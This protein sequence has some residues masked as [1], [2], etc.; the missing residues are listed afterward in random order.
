MIT[1]CTRWTSLWYVQ[2]RWVRHVTQ[3]NCNRQLCTTICTVP[4]LNTWHHSVTAISSCMFRSSHPRVELAICDR[5]DDLLDRRSPANAAGAE[6]R[7]PKIIASRIT[8][9]LIWTAM[10]PAVSSMICHTVIC[11][12][13]R[14]ETAPCA[15]NSIAARMHAVSYEHKAAAFVLLQRCSEYQPLS[16]SQWPT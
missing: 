5:S 3:C 8:L 15:R 1:V 10:V 2:F 13:M 14:F 4:L 9:M 12:V 7:T 16:M 11:L 6:R